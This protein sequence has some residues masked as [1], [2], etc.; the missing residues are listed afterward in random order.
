MK[1]MKL[2][3][4]A[5]IVSL[6]FTNTT[7]AKSY[8]TLPDPEWS[9]E[10][11][12]SSPDLEK[13]G[14]T[15]YIIDSNGVQFIHDS[16]GSKKNLIKNRGEVQHFT[17]DNA[18]D[19]KNGNYYTVL[20]SKVNNKKVTQLYAYDKSGK[21]LWSKTF[22]EKLNDLNNVYITRDGNVLVTSRVSS[23]NFMVYK[24]DKNGKL[25]KKKQIKEHIYRYENGFLVTTSTIKNK[26]YDTLYD[27][28]LNLKF[29]YER[30]G[31][32]AAEY[33][34]KDGTVYYN[35]FDG[36]KYSGFG[37]RGTNGKEIWSFP[38]NGFEELKFVENKLMI[39][40]WKNFTIS[41]YDKKG[42]VLKKLKF[43]K[44]IDVDTTSDNKILIVEN[45]KLTILNGTDLKQISQIT[46]P[47][48]VPYKTKFHLKED[49]NLY[50]TVAGKTISKYL[51]N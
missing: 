14:A 19:N 45:T 48:F 1:K 26:F 17:G 34:D 35:T 15:V 29:K 23:Y 41:L 39:I 11:K 10:Y 47:E 30:S 24:L 3:V 50:V 32:K 6:L 18:I 27:D 4:S 16:N 37:A 51:L 13:S 8:A 2:I 42:K 43:N 31:N 36:K 33:I 22:S 38:S 49:F 28:Q 25:L 46:V 12:Y 7:S 40:D 5:L 20:S 21:K 44:I 9:S